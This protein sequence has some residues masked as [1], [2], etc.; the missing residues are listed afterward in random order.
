MDSFRQCHILI[1]YKLAFEHHKSYRSLHI[2]HWL[3]LSHSKENGGAVLRNISVQNDDPI[4]NRTESFTFCLRF[5]L[6]VLGTTSKQKRGN[7]ILLGNP[8]FVQ[9]WAVYPNREVM[10]YQASLF[11]RGDPF[12]TFAERERGQKIRPKYECSKRGCVNLAL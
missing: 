3:L 10:H 2:W 1:K 9:L 11:V 8:R 7:V 6:Q 5:Y 4:L 12:I